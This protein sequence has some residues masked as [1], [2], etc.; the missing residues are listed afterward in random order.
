MNQ[1]WTEAKKAYDFGLPLIDKNTDDYWQAYANYAIV[2]AKLGDPERANEMII[3][4]DEHGYTNG[5]ACRSLAS[6]L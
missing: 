3:E 2:I 6:I 4:A 5:N 1:R